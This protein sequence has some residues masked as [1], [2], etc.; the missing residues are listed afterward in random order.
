MET[1]IAARQGT[2]R[3][4][5][6]YTELQNLAAT[7]EVHNL[8]HCIVAV[9]VILAATYTAGLLTILSSVFLVSQVP[10]TSLYTKKLD[11]QENVIM[12]MLNEKKLTVEPDTTDKIKTDFNS[13]YMLRNVDVVNVLKTSILLASIKS[14]TPF[15]QSNN[16]DNYKLDKD[17]NNVQYISWDYWNV[18]IMDWLAK[19]SEF[20]TSF[21]WN[22]LLNITL[23]FW[24]HPYQTLNALN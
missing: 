17:N 21:T 24:K 2:S 13:K 12:P 16:T 23:I 11:S 1:S 7:I 14:C 22:C 5:F 19:S 15:N 4:Y 3:G 9:S 10:G 18:P 8:I 20:V 6:T